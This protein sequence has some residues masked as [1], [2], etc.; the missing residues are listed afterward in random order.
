MT[1]QL[2]PPFPE[3]TNFAKLGRPAPTAYHDQHGNLVRCGSD[4]AAFVKLD[5]DVSRLNT[6]H[7]YLW[8]AGR[9]T[10]A[11]SLHRQKMIER[12]ILI[13]EQADLHM[14]WHESRIF[15]KPLPDYIFDYEFWKGTIC[16]DAALHASFC[17]FLL[18][19]VWL[20][21]H[22]SDLKIALEL[23]LI[24]S[25]ISWEGWTVFVDTFLLNID[26]EALDT[27]NKR[28]HYGELRLSRLNAIYRLLHIFEP[29]RFMLGYMHGYNRYTV[30][31]ERNFGWLVIILLYTTTTLGAMQVGLGTTEL[32]QDKNFQRASYGFAVSSVMLLVFVVF[33]EVLLFS[34]FFVFNLVASKAFLN[35]RR[36]QRRALIQFKTAQVP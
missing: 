4:S 27:V 21:R 17:G 32:Q 8:L 20:I 2:L 13:T 26:Y 24:S 15:L 14:V 25:K 33:L 35:R 19:Y 22:P 1:R 23:G 30:F 11:R 7:Q 10:N 31:F 6:I 28:C 9:P 5:M 16:N 18:S 34:W 36:Q 29:K 12:Q 3:D